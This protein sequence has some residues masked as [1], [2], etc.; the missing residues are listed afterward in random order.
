MKLSQERKASVAGDG[1]EGPSAGLEPGR[2]ERQFT[3]WT[4]E[5]AVGVEAIDQQHRQICEAIASLREGMKSHELWRV[6]GVL[7]ALQRYADVHFTTEEAEMARTDYP[8][9]DAHHAAHAQ[10]GAE[11]L[12]HK[13]CLDD[14]MTAS[15]VLELSTWLADWIREHIRG[16]DGAMGRFLRARQAPSSRPRPGTRR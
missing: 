8:G 4:D 13:A 2:R 15:A 7:Q 14:A 11:L 16:L 6:P 9:L 5:L 3:V 12:K 1:E 10:F